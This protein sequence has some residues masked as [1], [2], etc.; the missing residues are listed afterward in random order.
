MQLMVLILY[1]ELKLR[2]NEVVVYQFLRKNVIVMLVHLL[3]NNDIHIIKPALWTF[4]W[5]NMVVILTGK[6]ILT[7]AGRLGQYR[8][9]S[10]YY[11]IFIHSKVHN[12]II[13]TTFTCT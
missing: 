13:Y 4:E 10:Q 12:C 8:F 9:S 5:M 3:I 7:S 2:C 6:T 11:T 1:Q